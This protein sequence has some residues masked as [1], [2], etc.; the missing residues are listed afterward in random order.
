MTEP[1][2]PILEVE[3]DVLVDDVVGD[4]RR[5]VRRDPVL[6]YQTWHVLIGP[7]G[8]VQFVWMQV[9]PGLSR[10]YPDGRM[11]T[12]LGYHAYSP[13]FDDDEAMECDL[14][15][16]QDRCYYDGSALWADRVLNVWRAHDYDDGW[17]WAYLANA[18]R[19]T[20]DGGPAA[21]V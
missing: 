5:L 1:Q 10:M 7:K 17:L 21:L 9:P 13:Q 12:D 16:G 19:H 18:Y 14:L 11:G 4:F 20:F 6:S 3:W 15:V 2:P 8:A